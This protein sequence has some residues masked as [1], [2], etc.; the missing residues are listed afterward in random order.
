P[1]GH[2]DIV[3]VAFP[4]YLDY[5]QTLSPILGKIFGLVLSN[6]EKYKII[7]DNEALLKANSVELQNLNAIKDKF[8]SIIAHDL[9]SPFNSLFGFTTLFLE[10]YDDF[11]DHE[12][13]EF[14]HRI[15]NIS[16]NTFR[17]VENLLDWAGTQTGKYEVKPVAISLHQLILDNI[18]IFEPG[19]SK[20]KIRIKLRKSDDVTVFAD[21]YSLDA[22]IRNL[23]NNALK[24]T[25]PEGEIVLSFR[26]KDR[27]ALCSITD[28]GIGIPPTMVDQLFRIDSKVRR[29]GTSNETGTGLGLILCK[30]FVELNGGRI[31]VESVEEKGTTFFFTIPLVDRPGN[32]DE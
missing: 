10:E 19:A 3:N 29:D 4:Q 23:I 13:K 17:L 16:K 15:R 14:I 26:K 5:Y 21:K 7:R 12:K 32:L 18:S 9:R 25:K 30:E 6:A 22:I 20:K 24:F 1:I 27:M 31:W 2:I 8:F 28:T 11:T